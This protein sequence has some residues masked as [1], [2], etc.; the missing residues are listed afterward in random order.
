MASGEKKNENGNE[1]SFSEVEKCWRKQKKRASCETAERAR[2]RERTG[3]M[4]FER[5]YT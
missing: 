5:F 3:G 4:E 2:E 1:K